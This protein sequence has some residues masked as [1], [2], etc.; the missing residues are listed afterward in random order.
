MSEL[1]QKCVESW[2]RYCP[3]YQLKLWNE[4][5]Y[6]VENIAYTKAAYEQKKWAFVSDYVRMDVVYKYGGIYL[7]Q[8]LNL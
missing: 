3:G 7:V 8:M 5:N 4:D 2:K 6:D 1:I